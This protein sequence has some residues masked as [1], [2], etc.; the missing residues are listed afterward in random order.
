MRKRIPW[1]VVFIAVAVI[2]IGL[3]ALVRGYKQYRTCW[4]KGGVMT[5]MNGVQTCTVRIKR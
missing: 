3:I 1:I 2:V 5:K 4:D